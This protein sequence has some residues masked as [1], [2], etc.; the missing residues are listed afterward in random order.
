MRNSSK[1]WTCI[2]KDNLEKITK[3]STTLRQIL[4]ALN[5]KDIGG[6]YTTL[7]RRLIY[8]KIDFSHIPIGLSNCFGRKFMRDKIIY[9]FNE[10][11]VE[12]SIYSRGV[13]KQLILQNNLL[14]KCCSICQL[15][16]EWNNKKLVLILDHI[17]GVRNDHRLINLRFVCPNC[18][19]Q[20]DT[21][22]SKNL[23]TKQISIKQVTQELRQRKI[24]ENKNREK[25]RESI[26]KEILSTQENKYGILEKISKKL[27]ITHTHARRICDHLQVS[28]NKRKS[29]GGS[30]VE[31]STW[32][33]EVGGS[34]PLHQN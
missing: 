22:C 14:K 18:N 7:K 19:S 17:N 29:G 11:F 12:N 4:I 31:H 24:I 25:E 33:R 6:N 23:K 5:I 1:I 10:V 8:E 16:P 15:L 27:K 28:V 3:Q 9:N 32:A 20:L 30:T 13:A 21:H 26:I 34:S 2:S